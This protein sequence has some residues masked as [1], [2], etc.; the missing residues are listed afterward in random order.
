MNGSIRK[1]INAVRQSGVMKYYVVAI[2]LFYA[3][4][5]W[6]ELNGRRFLGDDADSREQ[7]RGFSRGGSHGSHRFYHK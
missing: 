6:A 5:V 1:L 7:Q 3:V 4:F 2:L